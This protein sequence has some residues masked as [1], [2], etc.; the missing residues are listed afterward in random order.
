MPLIPSLHITC[1]S[2]EPTFWG[3]EKKHY[4]TDVFTFGAEIL[5][6]IRQCLSN[7][8]NTLIMRDWCAIWPVGNKKE[9]N[10][11]RVKDKSILTWNNSV[12]DAVAR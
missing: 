6:V 1:F 11:L 12:D 9:K 10:C 4:F 7:R 5:G 2:T 8:L 3:A